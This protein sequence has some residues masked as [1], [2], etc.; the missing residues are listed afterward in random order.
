MFPYGKPHLKPN[1]KNIIYHWQLDV[2]L[3]YIKRM[4][5][6]GSLGY[7]DY[8]PKEIKKLDIYWVFIAI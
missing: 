6:L 2:K 3:R 8:F 7:L 1:K 4:G 5:P